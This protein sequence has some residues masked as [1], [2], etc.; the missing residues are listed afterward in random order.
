MSENDHKKEIRRMRL[1]LRKMSEMAEHV[2]QSGSFESG[3]RSSV[4]RYNAIV[5]HLEDIEALPDDLFPKL[6]ERADSGQLGAEAMLLGD[7]LDDLTEEDGKEEKS[8]KQK[9]DMGMLIALAPFLEKSELNKLVQSHF[10]TQPSA[11]EEPK[12][13]TGASGPDMET[14]VRLA[15]HV[16]RA[17]L[18]QMVRT[19]LASHRVTDP[20]Q[21]V[22]L[23]P[24]MDKREFSQMLLDHL[25]G[26]FGAQTPPAEE[27][28]EEVQAPAPPVSQELTTVPNPFY[29]GFDK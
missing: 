14:I 1:L 26:W 22:R 6:D 4:K 10:P 25:P 23:A 17:A 21:L 19:Y 11:P 18:G 5:E 2:E 28:V 16:D 27:E 29:S 8:H 24:H 12:A 13:A 15:P 3:I 20:N 9:P 7:Y